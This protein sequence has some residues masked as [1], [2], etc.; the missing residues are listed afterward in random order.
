MK[1]SYRSRWAAGLAGLLLLVPLVGSAQDHVVP[2]AGHEKMENAGV[3]IMPKPKAWD[4][5]NKPL[6][7]T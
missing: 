7:A 6:T 5:I 1:N 2:P 3:N 4:D